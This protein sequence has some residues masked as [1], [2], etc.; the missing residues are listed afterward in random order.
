MSHFQTTFETREDLFRSVG[1]SCMFPFFT[2]NFPCI[3]DFGNSRNSRK[4]NSKLK[5]PRFLMDGY[6]TVPREQFGCPILEDVFPNAGVER[7]VAISCIPQDYFGMDTVFDQDGNNLISINDDDGEPPL[8]T[9]DIFRIATQSTSRKELTDLFERGY[10]DAEQWCR[11]EEK[12][13]QR[14]KKEN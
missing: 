14:R 12:M 5:L 9:P 1:Y 4:I 11:R 2:T 6:F 7:T 13:D 10:R 3:I 8:S